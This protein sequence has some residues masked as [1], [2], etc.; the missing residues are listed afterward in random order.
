MLLPVPGEVKIG[1]FKF[2]SSLLTK[3]NEVLDLYNLEL[4]CE[5][6]LTGAWEVTEQ[7]VNSG[8]TEAGGG[9]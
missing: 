2:C 8:A 7:K 9:R 5:E 6:H 3:Q 4:Q 1:V